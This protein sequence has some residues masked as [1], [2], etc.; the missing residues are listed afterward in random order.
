M[1]AP[2]GVLFSAAL[3]LS[4]CDD[5]CVRDSDCPPGFLCEPSGRCDVPPAPQPGADAGDEGDEGAEAAGG[6]EAESAAGDD[7]S[8]GA[9]L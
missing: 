5:A 4:G 9:L 1:W 8:A 3:A 7:A 2:L 6:D